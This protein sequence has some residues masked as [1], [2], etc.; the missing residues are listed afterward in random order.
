[1][2]VLSSSSFQKSEWRDI[3][4]GRSKVQL[5]KIQLQ[6]EVAQRYSNFHEYVYNHMEHILF[7]LYGRL[8][9]SLRCCFIYKM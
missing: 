4:T 7:T 6:A 5:K 2:N 9:E 3:L 8:F 1:M